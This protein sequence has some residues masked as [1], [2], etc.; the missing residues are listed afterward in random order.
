MAD[1]LG[2]GLEGVIFDQSLTRSCSIQKS[3][4]IEVG[5]G[6][7]SGVLVLCSTA[8]MSLEI[9]LMPEQGVEGCEKERNL[10]VFLMARTGAHDESS[11]H[12]LIRELKR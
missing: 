5:A 7:G 3:H 10:A 9:N 2:E 6:L 4:L 12:I 8:A 1:S 11:V